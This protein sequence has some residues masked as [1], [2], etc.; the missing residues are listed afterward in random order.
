[1]REYADTGNSL[2][3]I[4]T[5]EVC[6]VYAETVDACVLQHAKIPPDS[7]S[8]CLSVKPS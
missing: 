8:D 3:H 1:M 2:D 5:E 7:R 4:V 6:V